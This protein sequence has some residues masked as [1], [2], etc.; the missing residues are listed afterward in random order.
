MCFNNKKN[1]AIVKAA[2]VVDCLLITLVYV[3]AVILT[4]ITLLVCLDVVARAVAKKSVTGVTEFTEYSLLYITFLCA[5][6]VL[7]R[8]A[9]VKIDILLKKL[10]KKNEALVNSISSLLGACVCS[11]LVW[12]GTY[13]ALD[14]LWRRSYQPTAIEIPDFPIFI[15]IPLGS[16]FLMIEFLRAAYINYQKWKKERES[17]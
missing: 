1:K 6:W 12:W 14:R 17:N 16:C 9:H 3:A 2:S 4:F 5:P 13:V 10:S 8:D 11:F 7:K 15:V